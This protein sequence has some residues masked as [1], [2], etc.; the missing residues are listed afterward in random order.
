MHSN[1]FRLVNGVSL[2]AILLLSACGGGKNDHSIGGT[3][4]GLSG[5]GLTSSVVLQDNGG[6]DLTLS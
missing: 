4:T 5:T 6:D 3:V 2:L 1:I